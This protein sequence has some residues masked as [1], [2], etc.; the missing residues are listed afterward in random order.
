[1]D[2]TIRCF[3]NDRAL[4]LPAGATVADA[5]RAFDGA[6][7]E[8]AL[9]GEAQ[10]TDARALPVPAAAPLAPGAILRVYVSARGAADD[11]HA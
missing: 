6:L 11:P 1:M 4:A 7:A 3:V 2:P 10:V 9:R 8:R 5:L